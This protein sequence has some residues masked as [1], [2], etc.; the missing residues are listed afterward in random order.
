MA[1]VRESIRLSDEEIRIFVEASKTVIVG[2]N[3]HDGVPHL[4][5]MWFAVIDGLVHMH[6]YRRSQKVVNLARDNRGS[7]LVEDGHRYAV[8]SCVV[9]MTS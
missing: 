6:T 2:T 9:V 1:D 4:V 7:L 5:P 8:F 3:N